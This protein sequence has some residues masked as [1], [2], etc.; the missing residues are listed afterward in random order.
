[1]SNRHLIEKLGLVVKNLQNRA[2]Y[3]ENSAGIGDDDLEDIIA[4]AAT[5]L[6]A[7][8]WKPIETAPKDAWIMLTVGSAIP[9][10]GR[11]VDDQRGKRWAYLEAENF[12]S[13]QSWQLECE[14]AIEAGCE[15]KPTHWMPIPSHF[16]LA[17]PEGE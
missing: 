17:P 7:F 12:C 13:E 5:A 11:W 8:E 16:D 4:G 3:S 14:A 2:Q 1:M 10:V 6:E 15:Y 9:T